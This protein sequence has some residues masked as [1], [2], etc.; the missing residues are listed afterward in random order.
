[1]LGVA[2]CFFLGLHMGFSALAGVL[3]VVLV[4][5]RD[6]AHFLARVDW[7]L[8][9]FFCGLFIVVEGLNSAGLVQP[10]VDASR[11]WLGLDRWIGIAAFSGL[12]AAGSNVVSNVP[13]V[14]L[15]GPLA[16]SLGRPELSWSLLAFVSTV[17][18]NL[19]L[20]GSVA[21]LI[22]AER[23][24]PDYELGFVEYLRYGVVATLASLA[25]GVPVLVAIASAFPA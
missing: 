10:V 14:L 25:A 6:P 13:M 23:A 7:S 9:V 19:T 8:L 1:M 20:V 5:R 11:E 16:E 21:N 2:L 12:V 17:A 4:Q 15:A 3:L 24:R 22:V 18:G